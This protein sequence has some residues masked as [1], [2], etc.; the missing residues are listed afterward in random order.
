MDE[1][2]RCAQIFVMSKGRVLADGPP[3][4]LQSRAK[5]LTFTAAP[6]EGM[7]AREL[8]ARLIDAPDLVVDAVPKGGN[9]SFIR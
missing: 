4:G 6:R 7:P 9:V 3:A 8:Q 1:A 5:G 2:E